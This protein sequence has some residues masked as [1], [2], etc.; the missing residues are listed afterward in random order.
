M[1]SLVSALSKAGQREL[2]DDLNYLNMGEIRGFCTRHSIPYVIWIE[3]KGGRRRK[4]PDQDRKG[5]VLNRI[6]HYLRTGKV[7]PETCF[8]A[9]VVCLD[10]PPVN[11]KA[12]DRLFYGQYGKKNPAMTG[13][14]ERLTAGKFRSGAVARM[15]AR[16]FWSK[17]TAPTF[18]EYAAAWLAASRSHT[19]PRPE[20]AYLSGRADRKMSANWK[21][22]RARKAKHVLGTLHRL[23]PG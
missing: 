16:E 9:R 12:T 5:V 7:L 20:W 11:V 13:L 1:P 18:Q 15:L 14:L 23:V 2:F 17:G 21:A 19:R 8:P 3:L 10:D 6:R 4:T 22:L